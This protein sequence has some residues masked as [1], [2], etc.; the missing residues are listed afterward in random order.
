MKLEHT[1]KSNLRQSSPAS[2][3][4]K[5][6]QIILYNYG[7]DVKEEDLCRIAKE[8]GWYDE[9][10]GVYLKDNGKLIGCFGINYKHSL[11]NRIDHIK[12][13][14]RLCHSVMVCLNHAKLMGRPDKYN[15]ASHAVIVN[16]I[17]DKNVFITNPS[18][19]VYNECY[20]INTFNQAWKDSEYYMLSTTQREIYQYD[21]D[22]RI[23]IE[24]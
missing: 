12:N 5:C 22:L 13:E 20:P 11:Y 1:S 6:Q 18:T 4:I 23:M 10:V 24:I 9:E 19:G 17:N 8:N 14:R 15:Q 3:A 7:I 21:M 2:C 16:S